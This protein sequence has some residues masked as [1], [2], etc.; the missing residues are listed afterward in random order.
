LQLLALVLD[1]VGEQ[2]QE[3]ADSR[4]KALTLV[5]SANPPEARAAS[6]NRSQSR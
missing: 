2:E 6:E 5:K 3:G 4:S 1:Q